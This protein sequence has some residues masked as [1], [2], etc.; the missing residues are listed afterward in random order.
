VLEREPDVDDPQPR[1][2]DVEH[3]LQLLQRA[4][5]VEALDALGAEP[6]GSAR[7]RDLGHR[8]RHVPEHDVEHAGR[9]D[10][11]PHEHGDLVLH[12]GPHLADRERRERPV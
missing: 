1:V 8:R 11:A 12:R 10:E 6:L 4:H 5:L 2:D 7:S 3:R 9:P